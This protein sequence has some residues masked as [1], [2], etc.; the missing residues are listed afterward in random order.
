MTREHSMPNSGQ[1]SGNEVSPDSLMSDFRG[2]PIVAILA[3]TLVV[4][5]VL[6]GV[7]SIGYLKNHFLGE[8]TS[9]MSKEERLDIAV[10]EATTSLR[11]IA[12]RHGLS[13][14]ELSSRFAADD[15]RS[16][17][18]AGQP[19]A[20]PGSQ[21]TGP[22][23]QNTPPEAEEP[24]SAIEKTLQEKAVGPEL[25]DLVPEDEDDLF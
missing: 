1:F 11:K 14:Q 16:I 21:P 18:T 23:G 17:P 5:S 13:P 9:G 8:D 4:H 19:A 15:A 20:A 3:V 22:I 10:R 7:F 24:E 25:P 2:R 6:V 12:E